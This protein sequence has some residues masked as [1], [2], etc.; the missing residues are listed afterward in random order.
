MT[1]HRHFP[2]PVV[3][4]NEYSLAPADTPHHFFTGLGDPSLPQADSLTYSGDAQRL[5]LLRR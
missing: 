5:P 4:A 1:K 2:T 3:N